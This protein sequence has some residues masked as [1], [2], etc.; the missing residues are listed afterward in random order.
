MGMKSGGKTLDRWLKDVP[1]AEWTKRPRAKDDLREKAIELRRK[2]WSYREIRE[3]VPVSKSSLSLWLKD[4]VLTEEHRERLAAMRHQSRTSAGRTIQARRLA[5]RQATIEVARSQVTQLAESE[6][7]VSGLA[8]YWSEGTKAKP[9]RASDRVTFMN[10]DPDLIRLFL[11]WMNLIGVSFDRL[12]FRVAIHETADIEAA[13]RFW[14]GIVGA[15]PEQ[16]RSTVI[17]R[18]NPKTVRK[19]VGDGY[20][21]CLTVDVLRSTELYRQIEGWWYGLVGALGSLRMPSIRGGVIGSTGH[22]G[23]SSSG[24]T[25]D[26]GARSINYLECSVQKVRLPL[27]WGASVQWHP[28]PSSSLRSKTGHNGGMAKGGS[29]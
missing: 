14:A 19:N 20:H 13:N 23:C 12:T 15:P 27:D 29:P 1:P 3:V 8:A 6:L 18:H 22:F 24:S 16:F 11:A 28:S 9:W 5:R 21:G 4:V 17:K 25:P 7:F 2:G 10:S 26:P